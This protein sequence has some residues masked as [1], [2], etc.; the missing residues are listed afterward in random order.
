M[1]QMIGM[2]FHDRECPIDLLEQHHASKFVRQSHPAQGQNKTGLTPPFFAK[3][4]RAANCEKQRER[5]Y[6]LALMK[7]SQFLGRKLFPSRI[8]QDQLVA[9]LLP[10]S[11]SKRQ[12]PRLVFER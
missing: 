12:N 9:V 4:I 1:P 11:A 3:P 8:E 6:L 7:R 5:L 10:L 2:I